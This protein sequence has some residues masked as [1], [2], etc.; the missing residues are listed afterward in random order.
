MKSTKTNVACNNFKWDAHSAIRKA[1][2]DKDLSTDV[3]LCRGIPVTVSIKTPQHDPEIDAYRNCLNC[4]K[5]VNYH[6]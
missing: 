3:D 2:S 6:K 1:I 5:H 4:G